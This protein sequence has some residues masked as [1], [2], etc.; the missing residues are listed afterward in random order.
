[1]STDERM[2][3]KGPAAIKLWKRGKEAWNQWVKEHPEAEINFSRVNFGRYRNDPE[4]QIPA[5]EW[6]FAG[7]SFRRGR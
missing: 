1:M 3:L 5:H 7:F 2:T 6:P 4:C